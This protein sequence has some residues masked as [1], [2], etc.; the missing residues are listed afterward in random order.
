M[1]KCECGK[2]FKK[3]SSL[4]SHVRFCNLYIKKS[5]KQSIY[6]I[7]ENLYKCECG[8][9][10]NKSQSLNAHFSYCIIHR[11]GIPSTRQNFVKGIM[12]GWDKFSK[13]KLNKIHKQ[14]GKTLSRKIE[15]GDI[16][17]G[18]LGKKHTI[19]TKEKMSASSNEKNNGFV[20]TKY[21]EVFC[22]H[23]NKIIKVQ[24]TWEFKYAKYLNKNNIKWIRNK[25]ISLK[26][27]LYKTDYN[28]T[29]YPDFY[30]ISTDEYVEI[31][32]FWWKSKD[33][34]VNDKRKMEKVKQCNPDKKIIIYQKTELEKMKIL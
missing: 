30:L 14:A 8:K 22:P 2:E 6:K 32:G 17:P 27:K 33:G 15:S 12:H 7:K 10:F 4:N 18:F 9:N 34:R 26:Y 13:E 23:L 29:Y 3:Q 21:Y 11:K 20:K 5:K 25:K 1:Y 19:K 24:G 31:K 28:H 16:I